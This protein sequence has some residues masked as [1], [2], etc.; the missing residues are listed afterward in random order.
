MPWDAENIL[1][2]SHQQENYESTQPV[3]FPFENWLSEYWQFQ[4][5]QDPSKGMFHLS[6]PQIS[7]AASPCTGAQWKDPHMHLAL[8]SHLLFA[9]FFFFT[10]KG[11]IFSFIRLNWIDGILC[12]C[13]IQN[14][15]MFA[16][17]K[18]EKQSVVMFAESSGTGRKLPNSWFLMGAGWTEAFGIEVG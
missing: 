16:C 9:F 18:N 10:Y 5:L 3:S 15:S 8:H 14:D 17:T 11:N 2:K 7:G 12:Q 4:L 1:F 13:K 6:D